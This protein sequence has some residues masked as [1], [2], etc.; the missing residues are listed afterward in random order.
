MFTLEVYKF[1]YS[2]VKWNFLFLL[3]I[4]IVIFLNA[5]QIDPR[6]IYNPLLNKED[7]NWLYLNTSF[8]EFYFFFFIIAQFILIAFIIGI[9]KQARLLSGIAFTCRSKILYWVVKFGFVQWVIFLFMILSMVIPGLLNMVVS[10]FQ[11]LNGSF[12]IT[13]AFLLVTTQLVLLAATTLVFIGSIFLSQIHHIIFFGMIVFFWMFVL[14]YSPVALVVEHLSN[15]NMLSLD[16]KAFIWEI[17]SFT[18]IRTSLFYTLAI[19]VI[20]IGIG[21]LLQKKRFIYQ[22]FYGFGFLIFLLS[23]CGNSQNSSGSTE[24]PSNQENHFVSWLDTV[25]MTDK[26]GQVLILQDHIQT[27]NTKIIYL[28]FWNS[29]CIPCMK[30]FPRLNKLVDQFEASDFRIVYLNTDQSRERWQRAL[31]FTKNRDHPDHY[32]ILNVHPN[33]LNLVGLNIYPRYVALDGQGDI[34]ELSTLAP[35]HENIVQYLARK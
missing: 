7:L 20:T 24:D 17:T 22:L 10:D 30:E 29:F 21:V 5:T 28:D 23:G 4:S 26:E 2:P 6:F 18:T 14:P 9:D 34:L 19:I 1:F 15:F 27:L 13:S 35:A 32:Q 8:S 11:S 16:R 12:F 3:S 31:S 25:R 33:V